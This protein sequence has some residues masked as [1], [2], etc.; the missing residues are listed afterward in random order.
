M[1]HYSILLCGLVMSA[2]TVTS[3]SEYSIMDDNVIRMGL[4]GE[5][6]SE[7]FEAMYGKISPSQTWDFSR[8]NLARQ[9]LAGGPTIATAETRAAET[10]AIASDYTDVDLTGNTDLY[11]GS[12]A[13]ADN[14]PLYDN[15]N[16]NVPTGW[17]EVD[18]NGTKTWMDTNLTEATSNRDKGQPFGLGKPN[19]GFMII[20]IYQGQ[21]GMRWDLHIV[22]EGSKNDYKIWSRSAGLLYKETSEDGTNW[23]IPS[24]GSGS[25]Y[26]NEHTVGREAVLGRPLY[27]APSQFEGDSFFYLEVTEGSSTYANTG[28]KQRSDKGMMLAL[29][30]AR[31]D[32]L[33]TFIEA[34]ISAGKI[35]LPTGQTAANC[36]AMIMGCEDANLSGSDWDMN[37]IVFLVVGFPEL[38]HVKE[39]IKKRYMIEDLGSTFDFDFN[40][41]VLDVTRVNS[42]KIEGG[43]MVAVNGESSTKASLYRLCGTIPFQIKI[44]NQ[45]LG[46]EEGVHDG[47]FRG[48]NNGCSEG[49]TGYTPTGSDEWQRLADIDVTDWDPDANNIT[50]TTWPKAAG[51]TDVDEGGN[52][53][54]KYLGAANG[55]TFTFPEDG[56]YPFIIACD[57]SVEPMA[58]MKHVPANWYSVWNVVTK[59]DVDPV[60]PEGGENTCT[61]GNS[62]WSDT[63]ALQSWSNHP[64]SKDVFGSV[65]NNDVLHFHFT[66][67]NANAKA[68][69]FF[70]NW[71]DPIVAETDLINCATPYCITYKVTDVG[72]LKDH[73]LVFQGQDCVLTGITV[74]PAYVALQ[75]DATLGET[76][77]FALNDWADAV[78]ISGSQ[79]SSIVAGDKIVVTLSNVQQGAQIAVKGMWNN[80]QPTLG[81]KDLSTDET[82]FAVT[83]SASD[84]ENIKNNG[85]AIQGHGFTVVSVSKVEAVKYTISVTAGENGTVTGGGSFAEGS[86]VTLTATPADGYR[87]KA[88]HGGTAEGKTTNTV[89]VTVGAEDAAYFVEF[90]EKPASSEVVLFEGTIT[91][92]NN[93]DQIPVL[94]FT[95]EQKEL[96]TAGKTIKIFCSVSSWL[97]I[98]PKDSRDQIATENGSGFRSIVVTDGNASTIQN[99]IRFQGE[100]AT[101]TKVTIE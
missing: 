62:I 24:A 14:I 99:G 1:K 15:G 73:G 51:W 85:I 17:Y 23:K 22:D 84:V 4:F 32:N 56:K 78:K 25:S 8:Y 69:V 74:V 41:I 20:P 31:P 70:G 13:P 21:A 89:Q 33:N 61:E 92:N 68:K 95:E 90:E 37:D 81:S 16:L 7:N 57:Q 9:G 59:E 3:C 45:I 75:T 96:I 53:K 60:T 83:V 18:V 30:C 97:N 55:Q 36:E 77:N 6:Y 26:D 47:I 43:S 39:I 10:R 82:S 38:P 101:I 65:N 48:F 46:Y 94:E 44:G 100:G 91:A 98:I 58:E 12:T 88:W 11:K 64:I 87:V 19:Y 34:Q 86:T 54:E 71:G 76:V 50:V 40:D 72:R 29:N 66:A 52:A 35:A 2:L 67:T 79:L 93:G 5:E 28:A 80:W 42:Y 27:L 63:E 49:G